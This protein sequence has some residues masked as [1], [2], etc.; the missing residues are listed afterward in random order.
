MEFNITNSA[1]TT[2]NILSAVNTG[3]GGPIATISKSYSAPQSYHTRTQTDT[4][5]MDGRGLE[6]KNTRKCT[7]TFSVEAMVFSHSF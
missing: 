6:E 7:Q 2:R 5:R 1:Y 3:I 4:G